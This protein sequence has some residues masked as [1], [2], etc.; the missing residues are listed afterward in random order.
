MDIRDL[1]V[2]LAVRIRQLERELGAK[3]FDQL[4]KKVVLTEAGRL[5]EPYA[6]RVVAALDDARHVIAEMQGLERGALRIGAST[7]PGMYLIPRT[8]AHFKRSDVKLS[9]LDGNQSLRFQLGFHRER[10]N[11]GNTEPILYCLLNRFGISHFHNSLYIN[12]VF[13]QMGSNYSLSR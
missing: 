8:I 2:F 13:S 6:R 12:A 5:L 10:R 4:G 3:L 9:N 1:Q 7:T 11:K